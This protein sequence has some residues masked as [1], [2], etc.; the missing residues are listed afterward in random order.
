MVDVTEEDDVNGKLI[1]LR[2]WDIHRTIWIG[3][4]W[5]GDWKGGKT[6]CVQ[7]W[8]LLPPVLA[9]SFH[10]VVVRS[11]DFIC[12]QSTES[13][14][15]T[16]HNTYLFSLFFI[17][18]VVCVQCT[19]YSIVIDNQIDCSYH[20]FIHKPFSSLSAISTKLILTWIYNGPFVV[21]FCNCQFDSFTIYEKENRCGLD[22]RH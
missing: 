20:E 6:W 18:F 5:L 9:F 12:I 7:M 10:S 4:A 13:V 16:V 21:T 15:C 8:L 22:I 1:K 19:L 11:I 3:C 14:P 17:Q 2:N